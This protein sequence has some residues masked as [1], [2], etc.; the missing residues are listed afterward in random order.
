MERENGDKGTH[1]KQG[2]K[3]MN[4]FLSATLN[5]K[6]NVQNWAMDFMNS[7]LPLGFLLVAIRSLLRSASQ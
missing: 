4:R 6:P 5:S 1:Q 2:R 7:I 3:S